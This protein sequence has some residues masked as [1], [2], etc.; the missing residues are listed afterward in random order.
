MSALHIEESGGGRPAD[1]P[2]DPISA[3]FGLLEPM[4]P[5]ELDLSVGA[6]R[7]FAALDHLWSSTPKLD[8]RRL[9]GS[10]PGTQGTAHL[11]SA[12]QVLRSA[13]RG[14]QLNSAGIVATH[15]ALDGLCHAL[16]PLP[17]SSLVFFASPGW[18]FQ[19]PITRAGH[20]PRAIPWRLEDPVEVWLDGVAREISTLRRRAG[21]IVNFPRNPSGAVATD[22]DWA[23]IADLVARHDVLLIVDDVYSFQD[24]SRRP[25]CVNRQRVVV[26]DS[27]SKRLG[28]PGLRLGYV[29]SPAD[30]LPVVRASAARTSVGVSPLVAKLAALALEAYVE[31]QLWRAVT[32]ELDERRARTREAAAQLGDQLVLGDYGLYGCI[33]LPGFASPDRFAASLR[34]ASGI[35]LSTGRDA[36]GCYLRFCL[37]SHREVHQAIRTVAEGLSS[38]HVRGTARQR[39]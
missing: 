20:V 24:P 7:G 35:R 31:Q 27:V 39:R 15:G 38:S 36:N 16:A 11:V 1:E 33:R 21:L 13:E 9:L 29:H 8:L 3:L 5:G 30:L 28:A 34:S 2:V 22:D 18:L 4:E 10:Y 37:G 26:V 12:L 6:L 17:A 32:V 23:R 25:A 14:E 19:I